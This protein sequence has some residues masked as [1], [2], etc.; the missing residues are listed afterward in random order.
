M[1]FR[2][3]DRFHFGHL[4]SPARSMCTSG[5][6][7]G[8][9]PL[10][11]E[12]VRSSGGRQRRRAALHRAPRVIEILEDRQLMSTVT[13]I[14]HASARPSH[15]NA[16]VESRTKSTTSTPV[17]YYDAVNTT[18]ASQYPISGWQGIRNGD[19]PGQ[20]LITGT[21]NATGILY[22]GSINGQGTSNS[23]MVTGSSSTSVYGPNNL[24]G[25]QVQL[26]GSYRTTDSSVVSGFFF[27]GTVSD[28]SVTGTYS[29]IAA[30]GATFNYVHSTM[31]GL[32]VGNSDGPTPGG[33]PLGPGTAFIYNVT[34]DR[35]VANV[36]FP[37]S[38]SNT[39]YGIWFNGGTSYT[40]VGGFSN[41]AKNNMSNQDSPIGT[42]YI[43]DYN[44]ASGQF[45][46]W[47][48]Y[49]YP[50]GVN[51]LTHFEGISSP[52]PG[53]YTLAADSIQIGTRHLTQG[54]L[55]VV[56]RRPNGSFGASSW[57]N[58]NYPHV[59]GWTSNDSVAGNQ[60]VGIVLGNTGEITYQATV[61]TGA[62]SV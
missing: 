59:K 40:I 25:G 61:P 42:G 8:V 50:D 5:R 54:S 10:S 17:I 39:A 22:V 34:T 21:S 32:A 44:S 31:G 26:V 7:G 56:K 28:G 4:L 47:K 35:F 36:R 2:C 33:L 15:H 13:P 23:V 20:Y 43:V 14:H 46:H 29:T 58:L 49:S 45:S 16:T 60:A 6:A 19:S 57:V 27:Q 9:S 1:P 18:D 24:G 11:G 52:A 37:G 62:K 41:R 55:V 3:L 48:A 12:Q 30:P 53:V 51:F 38:I